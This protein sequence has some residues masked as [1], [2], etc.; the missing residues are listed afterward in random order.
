MD[1]CIHL[2]AADIVYR[3][4]AQI[5]A[6]LTAAGN[7]SSNKHQIYYELPRTDPMSCTLP[8]ALCGSV[9]QKRQFDRGHLSST[10]FSV[11]E[12]GIYGI[13]DSLER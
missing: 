7:N 5:P 8:Y 9:S 2:N 1:V 11:R 4:I 3:N 6:I 12:F 13:A 10:Y